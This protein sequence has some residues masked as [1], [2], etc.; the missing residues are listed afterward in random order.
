VGETTCD[1]KKKMYELLGRIKDVHVMR[2]PQDQGEAS[3]REWLSEVLRLKEAIEAKFGVTITDGDLRAAIRDRNLERAKLKEFYELSALVPPPMTGLGQ[4]RLLFGSQFKFDQAEK[5]AEIEGAIAGLK[6]AYARGERPVDPGRKRLVVTGCPMGG[7]TVKVVTALE[8]S[9]AVVVAY[10]NC[11][12]AKQYDRPIPEDGDIWRNLA[13]HYLAVGCAVMIPN[14]N[15]FEL[16]ERL[17]GQFSADGVVEM[18]LTAC[19]PYAV[20]S[21]SIRERLRARGTPFLSLETDYSATDVERLKTRSAAF[22][23]TLS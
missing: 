2:L 3:R 14:P 15:R 19:Q 10:E 20:E 12:G 9:G 1:G 4:L 8:D 6:E 18:V 16:L 13:D 22:I 5:I 17:V 7:A 23:E 21:H 11:T